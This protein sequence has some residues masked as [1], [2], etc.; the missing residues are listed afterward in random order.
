MANEAQVADKPTISVVVEQ[1]HLPSKS[2]S[3]EQGARL[4]NLLTQINLSKN[5]YWY[6]TAWLRKNN[7]LNYQHKKT[8]L[9]ALISEQI[10]LKN[11][12]QQ[13]WQQ[14]L[15]NV[16]AI[17]PSDRF[18][19]PVHPDRV[20]AD[21]QS[22]FL[23]QNGDTLLIPSR[24]NFVAIV[25]FTEQTQQ[26]HNATQDLLQY[27]ENSSAL[28]LADNSYVWLIKPDTSIEKLPIAYWNKR[29]PRFIAPG[30]TLYVPAK[31]QTFSNDYQAINQLY[32][33]LLQNQ[34]IGS[35]QGE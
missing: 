20:F 34:I 10:R 23:L 15:E 13:Q 28:S 33:E 29:E 9:T 35:S 16:S 31:E 25:G 32:L 26:P 3:L 11:K 18:V 19:T 6:A 5:D 12:H 4:S 24:P 30:S 2:Y 27:L 22:N 21:K 8:E 14:V 1:G 17:K 7:K